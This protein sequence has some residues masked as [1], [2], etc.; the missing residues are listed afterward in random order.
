MFVSPIHLSCSTAELRAG[1]T[2]ERL[3]ESDRN[4]FKGMISF[5]LE[6]PRS[7]KFFL[8]T[9]VLSYI[10]DEYNV[11]SQVGEIWNRSEGIS[12]QPEQF[13]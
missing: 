2:D 12:F 8:H 13:L 7:F 9:K 5:Q 10:E 4:I 3:Q 11:V 6:S 1:K